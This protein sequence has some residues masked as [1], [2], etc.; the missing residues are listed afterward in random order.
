MFLKAIN[1]LN[2]IEN[3]DNLYIG[4]V[5]SHGEKDDFNKLK[6]VFLKGAAL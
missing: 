6:D 4:R 5:F 3:L 2:S 1:K